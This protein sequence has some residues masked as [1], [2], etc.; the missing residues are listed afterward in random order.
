[1]VWKGRQT[2]IF[3]NWSHCQDQIMGFPGAQYK[4]FSSKL[5]AEQAFRQPYANFVDKTTK[6]KKTAPS[7]KSTPPTIEALCVDA[8]CSGNPGVMEYQGVMN[9][10]GGQVFHK[11][12]PVGTNNIGEFL[13]I[14][15]GLAWL[16]Q[17][18]S[19][20][21]IYTDSVNAMIWVDKAEC[22]TKLAETAETEELYDV[23]RRAELWL[24][25]NTFT[26]EILKWDTKTW[27]EIPADF[28]RK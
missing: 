25:N 24:K 11:K 6:K 14:V 16:K 19:N 2:G 10:E 1:M 12:F 8:A 9:K 20:L 17:H 22:K 28:G 3:L 13:A 27:G 26:T 15:H 5:E 7:G 18:K 21:P 23:I 4:S